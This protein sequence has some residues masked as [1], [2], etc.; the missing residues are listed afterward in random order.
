MLVAWLMIAFYQLSKYVNPNESST[1]TESILVISS[2]FQLCIG[3]SLILFWGNRTNE[4]QSIGLEHMLRVK[5]AETIS[6]GVMYIT[7]HKKCEGNRRALSES[8]NGFAQLCQGDS[9]ETASSLLQHQHST[10]VQ[11]QRGNTTATWVN[12]FTKQDGY[13]MPPPQE[14]HMLEALIATVRNE[15][16]NGGKDHWGAEDRRATLLGIIVMDRC[17]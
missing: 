4:L 6:K 1:D 17:A 15:H 16:T 7:E 12:R 3:I 2:T 11:N 13:P 9:C 14:F 8:E 10:T 5:Q